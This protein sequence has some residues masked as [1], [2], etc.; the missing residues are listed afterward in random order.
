[1]NSEIQLLLATIY[2]EA[3]NQSPSSWKAICS[4]IMNRKG[5]RE[6]K[7]FETLTDV[8]TKSGFDAYKQKNFPFTKAF[9]YFAE[10]GSVPVQPALERFKNNILYL[11]EGHEQPIPGIVLYYSP[12]A[13]TALHQKDPVHYT[14]IVPSWNFS[15]LVEVKVPGCEQDDFK[16]FK[17]K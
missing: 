10:G 1:M 2:G 15:Q 5:R 17:Y 6:W 7:H 12:L 9:K 14:H 13:Q 16:F 3:A 4:V 11:I 8:I